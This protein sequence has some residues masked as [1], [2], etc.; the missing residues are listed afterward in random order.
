VERHLVQRPFGL[1]VVGDPYDA[2]SPGAV[3]HPLRPFCRWWFTKRLQEQ[4]RRAAA[5][6][7]VTQRALQQRYPA[8]SYS[9]GVS[10]V[11]I[12]RDG[13]LESNREKV[14]SL[15]AGHPRA[16]RL[17]AVGSLAQ[18]Y[19]GTDTLIQA[20]ADCVLAGWD[21]S[22]TVVGGGKHQ[23]NLERL[24]EHLAIAPR[25]RFL[26]NV[27]SGSRVRAELDAA[28]LFVMPSRQEG[29]PRAMVEA[30]ARALPCVGSNVGGIPELLPGNCL[31][32]A[33]DAMALSRKIQEVLARPDRLTEMSTRN[34]ECARSFRDEVL[35]SARR[36]FYLRLREA[37]SEW[38]TKMHRSTLLQRDWEGC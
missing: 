25:V 38:L 31:V 21:L 32:P 14:A 9:V 6:A 35:A 15:Q 10:D 24:A 18:M 29:L 2:W 37:T 26:G 28:D 20:V 27:P 22:L 11:E 5:V 17:V 33:G 4:C 8:N 30:M 23:S 3:Y 13:L 36:A 19:K 7:F 1:E 12:G 34:L 16:F